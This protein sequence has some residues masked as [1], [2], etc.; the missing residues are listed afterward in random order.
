M[1]KTARKSGSRN[2]QLIHGLVKFGRS[3]SY[4]SKGIWAVKNKTS[5]PKKTI[6]K[7]KT[8]TKSFGK[9]GEKRSVVVPKSPNFYPTESVHKPLPRRKTEGPTRLRKSITPGTVLILLAGKHQGRRAVFLK[10][11]PSGSLLVTGPFKLNGVPLRRYNQSYVIATSTKVD[12]SGIKIDA[13]FDDEYFRKKEQ[14]KK[15]SEDQFFAQETKEKKT[16]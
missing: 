2:P 9:K 5:H 15:K 10:Q 13:K 1:P 4:H 16:C 14:K 3:R 12:I 7:T 11:L 8:I 6:E